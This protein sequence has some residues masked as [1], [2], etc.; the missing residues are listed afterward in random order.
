MTVVDV[1]APP[2]LLRAR[3]AKRADQESDASEATPEVLDR[4]IGS[5][6]PI[7][8]DE[9]LSVVRVNGSAGVSKAV[10]AK[11]HQSMSRAAPGSRIGV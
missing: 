7:V 3:I 10:I 2:S 9:G 6:E 11:I 1:Q 8:E 5:A 4:Q